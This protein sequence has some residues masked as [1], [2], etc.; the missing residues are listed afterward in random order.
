MEAGP[1]G[2]SW[3]ARGRCGLNGV[4]K[5]LPTL[6][7]HLSMEEELGVGGQCF[8]PEEL[9]TYTPDLVFERLSYYS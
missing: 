5:P 2:L 3:D 7:K 8:C 1:E 6:F 4:A 9:L